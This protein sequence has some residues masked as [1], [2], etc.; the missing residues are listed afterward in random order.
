MEVFIAIVA[1]VVS[2]WRPCA[3]SQIGA[4][5]PDRAMHAA[6]ELALRREKGKLHGGRMA[7]IARLI[8]RPE[9]NHRPGKWRKRSHSIWE[10]GRKMKT[11]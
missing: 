6:L 5:G 10:D 1:E 8:A 9:E 7:S 3:T 11:P 2:P 4:R